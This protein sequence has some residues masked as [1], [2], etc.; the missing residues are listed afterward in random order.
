MQPARAPA[1]QRRWVSFDVSELS[2]WP[3]I[4]RQRQCNRRIVAMSTVAFGCLF[5]AASALAMCCA[6]WY[7]RLFPSGDFAFMSVGPQQ[8]LDPKIL[9]HP[10][11][12]VPRTSEYSMPTS[13]DDLKKNFT[14]VTIQTNPEVAQ[15]AIGED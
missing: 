8:H 5:L 12:G 10:V 14:A 13:A 1:I 11:A 15:Q 4:S 9:L 7:S 6:A 3:Q 2:P